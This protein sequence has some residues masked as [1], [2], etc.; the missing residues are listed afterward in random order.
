MRRI[1]AFLLTILIAGIAAAVIAFGWFTQAVTA[2]GP[3]TAPVTVLIAPGS[4]LGG[5][6]HLLAAKG[7]IDRTWVFELQA[8]RTGQA[9]VLKPGEY[10]F[11]PGTSVVAALDKIVKRDVVIRFVTIPEGLTTG[12]AQM[13]VASAEGLSGP[14]TLEIAEGALLPETYGYEWGDSMDGV[15]KR[16]M[17]ARD[18]TLAALWDA[19]AENL[20]LETPEEAVTLASIVE[21]ET[22][23]ASERARVA[24]VFVN[25]LRRG[26]KLQSDPT[27]IYGIDGTR[28]DIDRALTRADLDAA[29]PYNTY[30]IARLPPGPI[31]NPGKDALAAVL[32]PATSDDLYFVADGSGGH[33]FAATLD[34]HNRNVARWRRLQRENRAKP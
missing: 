29:S 14:P 22:G 31:C 18:T 8:R 28:G 10:R 5:I 16:M 9:R 27:V 25:R 34:E 26:M 7:V 1:A 3:L 32:N 15:L 21:K 12:E 19:R 4:G 17:A 33:A 2:S 30:V 24:A 20:P 11:E 13:I 23:V 6:S